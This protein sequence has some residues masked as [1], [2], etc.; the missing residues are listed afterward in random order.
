M[1]AA[2]LAKRVDAGRRDS[3]GG[4]SLESGRPKPVI[5]AA[6][7]TRGPK[8][9]MLRGSGTLVFCGLCVLV[10]V[11]ASIYVNIHGKRAA[12]YDLLIASDAV[13]LALGL[14][15]RSLPAL[16]VAPGCASVAASLGGEG[17][18]FRAEWNA[19]SAALRVTWKGCEPDAAPTTL[20]TT[21]PSQPFVAAARGESVFSEK[22][23]NFQIRDRIVSQCVVQRVESVEAEERGSLVLSGGFDDASA[24]CRDARWRLRL[25]REAAPQQARF[26]LRIVSSRGLQRAQLAFAAPASPASAS[27]ASSGSSSSGSAGSSPPPPRAEPV[28]GTGV[29]FTHFNMR[30]HCVPVWVSEQGLGRSKPSVPWWLRAIL[31]QL[32]SG[33]TGDDYTTYAASASYISAAGVGLVLENDEFAHFDLGSGGSP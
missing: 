26:E 28:W 3:G 8:L 1:P 23:G 33:A 2:A 31:T 17:G 4:D 29:Q 5:T 24:D 19:T 12:H 11:A 10:G 9:Q 14:R 16:S 27:E 15:R 21:R 18:E 7:W 25:G 13:Q 32:A 22:Y 6:R 30:G 20:W